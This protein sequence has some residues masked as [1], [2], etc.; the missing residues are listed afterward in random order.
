VAYTEHQRL[1][2][3]SPVTI[4]LRARTVRRFSA[5]LDQHRAGR[6]LSS[7]RL[8]DLRAFVASRRDQVASA[9]QASEISYLKSF[10][11]GLLELGLLE[12]NPAVGL[13]SWRPHTTR[14]PISLV[15]VR[16]LLLEASRTRGEPSARKQAVAQRDR[17]CLELL[18]A[19][20]MRASEVVAT[21]AVDLDL[22]EA[23]VLVRRAKGG[24][25]RRLPLPGPTLDA[26]RAYLSEGRAVLLGER[27]D[28]G[29]LFLN[30]DG[31][32]L[33][34]QCLGLLVGR[35][36]KRA[37]VHAHPH[38]FRRTLATE[39]VRAGVN[40]PAVQKVL[41]HAQLT[42]TA[43]YVDVRLDEMRAGL[44]AFARDR[45]KCQADAGGRLPPAGLQSRLFPGAQLRAG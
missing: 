39:L 9:S 36:A 2:G 34:Q 41:G 17:A 5:W 18:F 15:C 32:E 37:E 35:V 13:K 19:T 33:S 23:L 30:R 12:Q 3:L 26:L 43:T 25:S 21:R 6:S 44:E 42:M 28:P 1:R 16:A 8:K 20:G 45:P 29:S 38:A 10:Y 31:G 7:A 27:P 24:V 11:K 14:R 22:D 40:L 4:G